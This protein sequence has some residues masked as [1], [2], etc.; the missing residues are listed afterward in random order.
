MTKR[1][2]KIAMTSAAVLLALGG[3]ARLAHAGAI[4]QGLLQVTGFQVTIPT[5]GVNIVSAGNTGS[6]DARLNG[7]EDSEDQSTTLLPFVLEAC[8]P[9]I[10]GCPQHVEGTAAD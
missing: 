1:N 5:T 8:V 3:Q 9:T 10:P 2:A 4:A 7:V 6:A